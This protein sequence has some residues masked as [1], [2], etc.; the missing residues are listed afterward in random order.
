[1]SRADLSPADRAQAR[2]WSALLRG[3]LQPH[4]AAV[5]AGANY[6]PDTINRAATAVAAGVTPGAVS[7]FVLGVRKPA[8][9]TRDALD[10]ALALGA[11][12]SD[13]PDARPHFLL[14]GFPADD[15]PP[16]GFLG[17]EDD[18]L[19]VCRSR[20]LAETLSTMLEGARGV[21][22]LA[23]V[24]VWPAAVDKLGAAASERVVLDRSDDED[25]TLAAVAAFLAGWL[26]Q[27]GPFA[28]RVRIPTEATTT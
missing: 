8:P 3:K 13:D 22:G 25:V 11:A 18:R 14:G 17:D 24:P 12:P 2:A 4:L 28:I 9:A 23:P 19:A 16:S 26:R 10:R 21:T 5:A 7:H 27:R 15:E 1:V 20:I 6:D